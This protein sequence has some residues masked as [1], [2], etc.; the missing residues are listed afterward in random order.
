MNTSGGDARHSSAPAYAPSRA[1]K[2]CKL[3]RD[4]GLLGEQV[5]APGAELLP[6]VQDHRRPDAFGLDLEGV[7]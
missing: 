3:V 1:L 5:E 4:T 6:P 7:S 2:P